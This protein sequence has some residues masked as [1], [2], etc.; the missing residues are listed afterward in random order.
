MSSGKYF[1]GDPHLYTITRINSKKF[2][3]YCNTTFIE[4][5]IEYC[6]HFSARTDNLK[7]QI[8]SGKIHDRTKFKQQ[9]RKKEKTIE[10][11]F[12][13]DTVNGATDNPFTQDGLYKNGLQSRHW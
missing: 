4:D 6:C 3:A 7:K 10:D 9:K 2:M 5:G 13:H 11:F 12:K 8:R 1:E